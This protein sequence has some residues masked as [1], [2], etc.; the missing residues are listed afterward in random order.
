MPVTEADRHLKRGL[1]CRKGNSDL[2]LSSAS[3]GHYR[4]AELKLFPI[5]ITV[6]QMNGM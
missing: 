4:Q 6:L 5:N 2:C 3:L 1:T